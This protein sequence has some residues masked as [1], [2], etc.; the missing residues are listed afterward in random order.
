MVD[1]SLPM[2]MLDL[3]DPTAV[4]K[5][6]SLKKGPGWLIA[7]G[8]CIAG[9]AAWLLVHRAD[10][11]NR[12]AAAIHN[13]RTIGLSLFEFENDYGKL[14][15]STT[16]LAVGRN[17]GTKL[18]LADHSSNDIFAQLIAAGVAKE[19]D[20]ATP[21]KST[22]VPDGICDSDA[23][24][25]AHGETGFAYIAGLSTKDVSSGKPLIVGPVI[26]GTTRFD[27]KAFGG[28]AV[29][30]NLGGS[31]PG[32]PATRFNISADGKLVDAQGNDVLDP[33]HLLWG[34]QSFTVK[35]PK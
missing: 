28:K 13:M 9:P 8:L 18:T 29:V 2:P 5:G 19:S 6:F 31:D 12:Q 33:K 35:W 23:T 30:L 15:D 22:V 14:P 11:N 26:P 16:A 24:I 7:A 21:S 20:F 25:L 10:V 34:G 1:L 27:P 32:K 4:R 17:M 3:P